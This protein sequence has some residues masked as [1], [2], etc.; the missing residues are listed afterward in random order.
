M[1]TSSSIESGATIPTAL[2]GEE[3][4][5]PTEPIH[6]KGGKESFMGR[7]D[8]GTDRQHKLDLDKHKEC[9][10]FSFIAMTFC[11]CFLRPIWKSNLKLSDKFR[12]GKNRNDTSLVL[13]YS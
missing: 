9:V 10:Q 7:L 4:V 12:F 11:R 13:T 5:K 8:K 1:G 3:I 2:G 6:I